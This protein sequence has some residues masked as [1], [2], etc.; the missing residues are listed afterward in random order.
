ML[1]LIIIGA[2]GLGREV[3]WLTR[4]INRVC[5]TFDILG[6]LD[7]NRARHGT[8]V[9]GIPVLGS[10]DLAGTYTADAQVRI[11]IAVGEPDVKR[12]IAARLAPL[13][14]S[15]ATLIDPQARGDWARITI[16]AGSVICAG[17]VL[18]TNICLG[19]HVVVNP[20]V[21]IGHDSVIGDYSTVAPQ[22]VISGSVTLGEGSYLGS[23]CSIRDEVIVGDWVIVGMGAV[24]TK[25]LPDAVVVTGVPA[26]VVRENK[27][28]R[29]WK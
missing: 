22:A 27:G 8:E 15:Y 4:E 23:N 2:G 7:D 20:L 9:D 6:F 17:A 11:V 29:V 1:K 26:Q 16:G 24:V 28:R 14:P 18:T 21:Y 10:I 3:L 25:A 13:N 5:P 12:E 19:N